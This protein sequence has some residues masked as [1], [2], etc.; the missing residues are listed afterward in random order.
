M[1]RSRSAARIRRAPTSASP[2]SWRPR[3]APARD[4]GYTFV[5]PPPEAMARLGHK[6]NARRL[7]Q[8]CGIPVVP[9]YDGGEETREAF[10][11]AARR[12]GYPLLV[13]A[14]AGGGGRGMRL[15]AEERDL[16]EALEG[17]RREARSAFGEGAL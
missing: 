17:A 5:G 14:A 16:P 8:R 7:A 10:L 6:G 4:A 13:K 3:V 12:L 9:G 2:G 11:E 1:G 15:V